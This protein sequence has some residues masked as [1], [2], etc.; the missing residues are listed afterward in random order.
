MVPRQIR[1]IDAMLSKLARTEGS[2]LHLK[3][4]PPSAVRVHGLLE[5]LEG[6]EALHPVETE[7]S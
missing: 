3:V 4:G 7:A 2:N 6:Y 1:S 5:Y